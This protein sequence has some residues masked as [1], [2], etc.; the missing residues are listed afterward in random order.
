MKKAILKQ[1]C[2]KPY[3]R[4]LAPYTFDDKVKFAHGKTIVSNLIIDG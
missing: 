3:Y 2:F 1:G 4:W